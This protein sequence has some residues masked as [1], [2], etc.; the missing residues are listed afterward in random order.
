[1]N[2]STVPNFEKVNLLE[3]YN[4]VNNYDKIC[5]SETFLDSLLLTESDNLKMSRYKMM[6]ANHPNNVERGILGK[7]RQSLISVIHI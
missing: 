1:M 7:L 2:S 6:R 4:T 5:P 3:V